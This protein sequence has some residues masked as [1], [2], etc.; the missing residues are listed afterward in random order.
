MKLGYMIGGGVLTIAC[1]MLLAWSL[2]DRS[3]A[4]ASIDG[5]EQARSAALS[6]FDQFWN[7]VSTDSAGVDAISIKV[8][9]PHTLSLIHI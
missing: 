6:S 2:D 8:S 3:S 9:I 4:K 1:G 7:K 5:M